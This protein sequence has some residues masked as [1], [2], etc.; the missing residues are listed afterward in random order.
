M[1]THTHTQAISL[2]VCRGVLYSSGT[3]LALRSWH[4]DTMEEVGAVLVSRYHPRPLTSGL[5]LS[6]SVSPISLSKQKAHDSMISAM[7]C[8]KQSLFTSSLGCIKVSLSE[9]FLQ[10]ARF[11]LN[12]HV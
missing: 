9:K 11:A 10:F 8:S 3:D 5:S 7:I 4:I 1:H 2:A 6:L 12:H